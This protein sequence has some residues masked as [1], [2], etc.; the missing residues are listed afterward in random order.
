MGYNHD[1]QPCKL[2]M[3]QNDDRIFGKW[4]DKPALEQWPAPMM[5]NLN[6]GIGIVIKQPPTWT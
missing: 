2:M 6:D 4:F 1:G 3:R 5:D